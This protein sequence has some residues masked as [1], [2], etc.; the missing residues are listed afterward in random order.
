MCKEEADFKHDQ[1]RARRACTLELCTAILRHCS[2]RA[3]AWAV[4]VQGRTESCCDSVAEDAVYHFSCYALF[5]TQH[6]LSGHGQCGRPEDGEMRT[7]FCDLRDWLEGSCELLTL[8]DL[9]KHMVEFLNAKGLLDVSDRVYS[10][11]H[12]KSKLQE[13]YGQHIYFAEVHGRK[14]VVCFQDLCSFIVSDA[15]YAQ[16]KRDDDSEK[17]RIIKTVA[18]LTVA[19]IR[20]MKSDL[21]TYRPLCSVENYHS[22]FLS[23]LLSTLLNSIVSDRWKS[24]AVGHCL[25]QAA[26][27]RSVI[28]TTVG[29]VH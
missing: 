16:Q 24:L 25:M 20:D 22:D 12:L 13:K 4:E 21:E 5:A 10:A 15:C 17:K 28:S 14:N 18:K 9:H 7:A 11:S 27:P 2:Q 29:S 26:R 8:D 19:E 23:P 3:D 1:S 6:S